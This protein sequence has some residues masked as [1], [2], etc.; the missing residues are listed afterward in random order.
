MCRSSRTVVS[1]PS[2][3]ALF[4][5]EHVADLQDSGLRRLDPVA[6]PGG[7]QHDHGGRPVPATSTSLWPT[8]TVSTSTTSQPG[9][10]EHA[11]RLR[12]RPRQPAEVA[13]GGHRADEHA[14]V[15]GVLL[16]PD[17]VAEQRPAGERR[18]RVD[19]EHPDPLPRRRGS[20]TSAVGRRRLARRPAHPVS[21]ITCARPAYGASAAITSRSA[22]RASST[23]E[24]SRA[25]ARGITRRGPDDQ[26]S[27]LDVEM[28]R[29]RS[30]QRR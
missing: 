8:P 13:A 9:G 29:V 25:T 18:R 2:R 19:G 24:I 30:G 14:R 21:P 23:S 11:Q 26:G 5:D 22:G 16:H 1:A 27:G 15:G 6:H 7:E 17:A 20:P 4:T 28:P 12:R 10:V 3:S